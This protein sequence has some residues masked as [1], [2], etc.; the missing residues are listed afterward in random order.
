MA[1]AT[2]WF[3]V[4]LTIMDGKID[5]FEATVEKMVAGSRKEPGTLAY[6]FCLSADRTQCR[7][8]EAYVDAHA[9]VAHL[10]GPVVKELVPE[11]LQVSAITGFEVFGDPGPEAAKMLAG[12]GATVFTSWHG[13]SR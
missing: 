12:L 1:N 10:T 11:L 13:F 8:V 3:T 9:V 4:S 2:T 5:A 6:E 7:L